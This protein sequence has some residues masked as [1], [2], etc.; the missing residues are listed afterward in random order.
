M[1]D[2]R[3]L[4]KRTPKEQVV[5]KLLVLYILNNHE[6]VDDT[7]AQKTI[8]FAENTMDSKGIK[9]FS[10]NFFRWHF[11]EFS[12]EL[13]SDLK[14]LKRDGL[15]TNNLEVTSKGKEILDKTKGLLETNSEITKRIDMFGAY[16]KNKSLTEVK[17]LA[18]TRIFRN[19]IAVKDMPLGKIILIKLDESKAKI[20]F[21]IDE[22]WIGTLEILFNKKLEQSLDT[23]IK[24]KEYIQFQV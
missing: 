14:E 22:G 15:I 23:A 18:Y 10:Y 16:T 19:G 11:G 21:Q 6:I 2:L 8:F 4:P 20:D 24:E 3:N 17:N 9:G 7:K 1:D 12:R 13:E 5:D